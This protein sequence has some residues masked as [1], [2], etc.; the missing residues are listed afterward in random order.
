MKLMRKLSLIIALCICLT[1]SSVYA[2]WTY[3]KD[4]DVADLNPSKAVNLTEAVFDG[5]YGEYSTNFT[6]LNILVDQKAPGEHIA[7]ITFSDDIVIT[8][9]P[10]VNAPGDYK[11]NGIPTKFNFFVT[12]DNWKY[13]TQNIFNV[14]TTQHDIDWVESTDDEGNTIF[15]FTIEKDDIINY[16]SLG[17]EFELDT[18]EKYREFE[19]ELAKGQIG[20]NVTDGLTASSGR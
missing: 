2:V 19:T 1:V 6:S 12:N 4:N 10:G 13:G 3:T 15:T 14:D 11:E 16:I 5:N 20:I 17:A 9:K 7:V 18:I 8:Y